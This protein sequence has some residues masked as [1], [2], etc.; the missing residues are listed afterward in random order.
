MRMLLNFAVTLAFS[1]LLGNVAVA[2]APS[3][4]HE[5]AGVTVLAVADDA[6]S[7]SVKSG[8]EVVTIVA[9]KEFKTRLENL[10]PGDRVTVTVAEEQ[11]TR[12]ADG[13]KTGTGGE[14]TTQTVLKDITAAGAI[15]AA[16]LFRVGVLLAAFV[17]LLVVALIA[18]R[19]KV[20]MLLIGKD[21]RYSNSKFQMAIWF[22]VL[23]VT[24]LAATWIRV[25]AGGLQFLGG[26]NLPQNLILLSGLSA[27]TFGAAKGITTK[28]VQDAQ[29][30]AREA[31]LGAGGDQNAATAA[32]EAA[33]QRAKP[34]AANEQER[35]I[36][37]NLVSD[38]KGEP[39]I[40]DFQM[41]VV[42]LLAVVVYFGQVFHFLG[43]ME[44]LLVVTIP[45]VD[46]TIL[47]TFGLGQGAYLTKK[48][49]GKD[50]A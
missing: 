20:P 34:P 47:A 45:D 39:D 35:G 1:C 33:K 25:S 30:N 8:A 6:S 11:K 13:Q 40:G 26:V 9:G 7:L 44:K 32:A 3:E 19:S 24:Y 16:R 21:G 29:R 48:Y 10:R 12:A 2:A 22:A 37:L 17:I 14:V 4:P 23:I 38:D 5:I 42:T 31:V 46:T 27:L 18:L 43:S 36:I 28:N 15:P 41:V 49:A 50:G